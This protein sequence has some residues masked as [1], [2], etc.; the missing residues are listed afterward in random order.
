MPISP[1]VSP[2]STS[3]VGSSST[4]SLHSLDLEEKTMFRDPFNSQE[5]IYPYNHNTRSAQWAPAYVEANKSTSA[6]SAR[7]RRV[8]RLVAPCSIAFN[9]VLFGLVL[10]MLAN[11]CAFSG[12]KC[13]YAGKGEKQDDGLKLLGEIKGIVPECKFLYQKTHNSAMS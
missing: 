11:P 10:F 8:R 4:H 13:V 2:R 12:R 7:G 1:S 9:V 6:L 3:P 5:H